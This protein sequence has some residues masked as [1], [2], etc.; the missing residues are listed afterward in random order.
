MSL[1]DEEYDNEEEA[2]QEPKGE[3]PNLRQLREKAKKADDAEKE[4]AALKRERAFEKAGVDVDHPLARTLLPTYTGDLTAEAV[5]AWLEQVGASAVFATKP[6][7]HPQAP[8][9]EP[10][11]KP[12]PTPDELL[13][14]Q[15]R[16]ALASGAEPGGPGQGED[17]WARSLDD[18]VTH[19]VTEGKSREEAMGLALSHIWDAAA[20]GDPR[21]VY[22]DS[23]V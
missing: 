23:T 22:Q 20:K 5:K 8:A 2:E 21:V 18:F 15:E 12:E 17:P 19:H 6:E 11:T 7:E 9:T 3:N 4:L 10:V 16:Q 1:Q 14:T 13:A